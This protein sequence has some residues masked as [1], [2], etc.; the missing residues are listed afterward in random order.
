MTGHLD[1]H[2]FNIIY[3]LTIFILKQKRLKNQGS[4]YHWS[5]QICESGETLRLQGEMNVWHPCGLTNIGRNTVRV[6]WSVGWGPGGL[7]RNPWWL[8]IPQNGVFFLHGLQQP[9][10][11]NHMGEFGMDF[12]FENT[13]F[14]KSKEVLKTKGVKGDVQKISDFLCR[15][16]TN[17]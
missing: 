17:F 9:P 3:D 16:V 6:G 1:Q 12:F 14:W 11:P 7:G 10:D 4:L 13:D 15:V 2:G 5:H 8:G